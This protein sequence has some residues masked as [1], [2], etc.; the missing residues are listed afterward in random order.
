MSGGL[1]VEP[2]DTCA[3]TLPD[4]PARE[5]AGGDKYWDNSAGARNVDERE[6]LAPGQ[7]AIQITGQCARTG[8]GRNLQANANG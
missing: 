4:Q 6:E 1:K 8:M 7:G 5:S 2:W 3:P